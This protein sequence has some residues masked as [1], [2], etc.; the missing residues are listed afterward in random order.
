MV[1]VGCQVFVGQSSG[2][3]QV[4]VRQSLGSRQAIVRQSV[5]SWHA[6]GRQFSGSHLWQLLESG[7]LCVLADIDEDPTVQKVI[8]EV[9]AAQ[10]AANAAANG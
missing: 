1:E 6:F 9:K 8:Q 5:C 7:H 3:C 4:V 10:S 2:V